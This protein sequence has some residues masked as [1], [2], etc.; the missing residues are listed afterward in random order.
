MTERIENYK[1]I[2]KKKKNNHD[3]IEILEKSKLNT[4]KILISIA[5]IHSY[6]IYDIFVSV[7][8]I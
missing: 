3:E 8:N 5:L 2:I 4:N 6:I 1:S 7:N